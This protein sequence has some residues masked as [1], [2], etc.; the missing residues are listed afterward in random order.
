MVNLPG[1]TLEEFRDKLLNLVNELERR[2]TELYAQ[3]AVLQAH[4]PD[5]QAQVQ[6]LIHAMQSGNHPQF[7]TVHQ[8]FDDMRQQIQQA[9]ED[10]Q[11]V[12]LFQ[13]FPPTGEPN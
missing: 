2:T 11:L 9:A 8:Q 5:W 10:H 12:E 6:E 7:Q 13:Q 3:R 4:V 1:V